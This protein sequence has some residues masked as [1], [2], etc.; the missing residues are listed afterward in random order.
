MTE[1]SNATLAELLTLRHQALHRLVRQLGDPSGR[2]IEAGTY[3]A[4]WGRVLPGVSL[5]VKGQMRTVS[6]RAPRE[7]DC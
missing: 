6:D 7:D 3:H 2:A 5:S 4:D 1:M